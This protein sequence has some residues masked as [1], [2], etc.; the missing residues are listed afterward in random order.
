[1][2]VARALDARG[3]P[4]VAE[5]ILGMLRQR[6]SADYLQTSAVI[7]PD[8]RVRSAVNDPNL[9]AG[10]GTG[11]AL[12]GERWQKL[13]SLPQVLDPRSLEEGE[14]GPEAVRELDVAERGER[15]DEVVIAV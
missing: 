13:Q 11:Y 3:F 7:G 5:A 12:E 14:A 1:L 6:V 15:A 8:W 4:E 10:P 2:E 9:Y